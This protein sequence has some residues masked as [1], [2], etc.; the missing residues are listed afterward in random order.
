MPRLIVVILLAVGLASCDMISVL[1][2]GLKYSKAVEDDLERATG[3]KPK[4]GF[5]W[6][7]GNLEVVTVTFPRVFDAKPLNELAEDIRAAVKKEFKQ[8]PEEIIL[9]FSL[10][11]TTSGRTA[12]ANE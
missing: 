3:V 6:T 8:T 2:D 9:G 10:N 4:V 11:A 12:Q 5:N 7:N 1:M